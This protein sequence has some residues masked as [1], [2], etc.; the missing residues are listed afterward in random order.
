MPEPVNVPTKGERDEDGS[1]ARYCTV[2]DPTTGL[3]T[4]EVKLAEAGRM[5]TVFD[6]ICTDF[7]QRIIGDTWQIEAF[8]STVN[9]SLGIVR[10]ADPANDLQIVH[11]LFLLNSVQLIGGVW[12]GT[13]IF[14]SPPILVGR[15]CGVQSYSPA[16][17]GFTN[18]ISGGEALS[19][20]D[21]IGMVS[22]RWH[23]GVPC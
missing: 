8:T 2:D 5:V 9:Q 22:L 21:P 11:I 12:Q 15:G 16:S 18:T 17:P 4:G 3:G 10:A 7:T 14:T 13:P 20:A 19:R 1:F 6:R 23:Y